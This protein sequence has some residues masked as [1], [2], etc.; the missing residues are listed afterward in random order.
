VQRLRPLL[1]S[2]TDLHTQVLGTLELQLQPTPMGE[3]LRSTATPWREVALAQGLQWQADIP[4]SLPV[5]DIDR[6]RLAQ[7][8]GNLLSNAIKYTPEGTVSVDTSVEEGFVCITVGDT[9]VGIEPSEQAKIFEPL[10]R[11]Q[12]ERRF[13]QGMGLGLS[14]ARDLVEA[15]GGSLGVESAPNEGSRFTIRLPLGHSES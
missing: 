15:H 11:S 5:L 3:W 13:P 4:D 12:R 14:I 7:A 9:G 8:L 6:D 10:Y 1:D 2:L